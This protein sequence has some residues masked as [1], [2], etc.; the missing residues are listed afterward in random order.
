MEGKYIYIFFKFIFLVWIQSKLSLALGLLFC[1]H[2]ALD[3]GRVHEIILCQI[4][5][6]SE[7]RYV[8]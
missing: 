5:M 3:R 1:L 6:V 7:T 4:I 2:S 8:A